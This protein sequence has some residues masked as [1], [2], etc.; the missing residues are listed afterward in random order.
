MARTLVLGTYNRKKRAELAELL[1]PY[2]FE[3]LTLED[4]PEA[5][6]VDEDGDTFLANAQEKARQQAVALQHWVLGEDSGLAVDALDGAPGIYSARYS[7]PE[8]TDESN[9]QKLIAALDDV[10]EAQR[11][12]HYVCHMSVSS[13][14]G[15]IVA[16]CEATCRGRIRRIPVGSG[17]F[18]YDPLFELVEYHQTFG[19]LGSDVKSVLSHR[20][21]AMRRMVP[22]LLRLA[23]RGDWLP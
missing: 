13:P 14:Q 10:A 15:E 11:T 9:N 18:G 1:E 22:Q 17:G 8:A 16:D 2:G 7:G 12:A 19:Q 3:L 21:R 6:E 4:F 23:A 20:A 5:Q